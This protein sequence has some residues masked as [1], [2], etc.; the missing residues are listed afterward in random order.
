MPCLQGIATSPGGEVIP[1]EP[2]GEVTRQKE[3]QSLFFPKSI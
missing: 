3:K 1:A 2:E